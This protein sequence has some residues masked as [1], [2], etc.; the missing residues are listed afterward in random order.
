MSHAPPRAPL[1]AWDLAPI[2]PSAKS[3]PQERPVATFLSASLRLLPPLLLH[4]DSQPTRIVAYGVAALSP[5]QR[6]RDLLASLF[7]PCNPSTMRSTVR[8]SVRQSVGSSVCPFVRSAS[9]STIHISRHPSHLPRQLLPTRRLEIDD[10]NFSRMLLFS[11]SRALFL[12]PSVSL[13][14]HHS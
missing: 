13:L 4:P 14:P 7:T 6:H 9:L 12:P 5:M 8:P 1:R 3:I 11:S 10:T 2:Q